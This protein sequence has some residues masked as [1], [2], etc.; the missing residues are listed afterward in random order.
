MKRAILLVALMLASPL[1]A[2][3]DPEWTACDF[4]TDPKAGLL[5]TKRW[6][7]LGK[8]AG[9]LD[10]LRGNRSGWTN[11]APG[12]RMPPLDACAKA[13]ASPDLTPQ[14]WPRR[15]SLL[16][17]QAAHRIAAGDAAGAL[18]DLDTVAQV[19]P[20]AADPAEVARTTT[21]AS[22]FLRGLAHAKLGTPEAARFY[23][24]AAAAR[25]WSG[26]VQGVAETLLAQVPGATAEQV[27]V[28]QRLVLIDVKGR[29]RRA[30]LRFAAGDHAGAL[31]D[32]RR[33]RPSVT[34]VTTVYVK[35]PNSIVVGMPG[36]P[37]KT[38]DPARVGAAAIAATL[39]GDAAQGREWIAE[40]KTKTAALPPM[41][42]MLAQMYDRERAIAELTRRLELVEVAEAH[43]AGRKDA[44]QS[45]LAAAAP[46]PDDD[47]TLRLAALVR[48]QP[49]P[50]RTP[51]GEVDPLRVLVLLPR[52]EGKTGGGGGVGEVLMGGSLLRSAQAGRNSYSKS[53]G[54]FKAGG[55]KEKQLADGRGTT[56]EFIGDTSSA[57]A[58]EE[59][60][61]LRAADLAREAGKPAF[62]VLDKRDLQ[63]TST[64]TRNGTPMGPATPAGYV[65]QLDVAFVDPASLPAELR[66]ESDRTIA[67]DDVERVLGPE[68]KPQP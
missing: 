41:G 8:E 32:W 33:V 27:A 38:I 44:A 2:R 56:I 1:A 47:A 19:V 45:L 54:F 3:E 55:F 62:V 23:G 53:R 52:Y 57:L 61:L 51:A 11:L 35:F 9:A 7:E 21:V 59:M 65:T 12:T 10:A 67:V 37:V 68:Y 48:G 64:L 40:A 43:A 30:R 34:D 39:A 13:L 49:V 14:E 17:A 20:A 66:D 58:T 24:R 63:R 50:P 29:E 4:G 18:K 31:T 16:Q 5:A 15:V 60:T 42:G 26:R 28:A 46:L 6:F 36:F 22:D 25:P